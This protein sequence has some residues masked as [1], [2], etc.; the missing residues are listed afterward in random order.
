MDST[1]L[2]D[3]CQ[4]INNEPH[5]IPFCSL[6]VLITLQSWLRMTQGDPDV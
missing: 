2:K 5:R 3:F 6:R 1:I 4:L